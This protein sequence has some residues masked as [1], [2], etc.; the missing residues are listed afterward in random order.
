MCARRIR[1]GMVA[2]TVPSAS[3]VRAR[4][5]PRAQSLPR[6]RSPEPGDGGAV[7]RIARESSLDLNSPYAYVMWGD[8]FASTSVVAEAHGE[9]VGFVTGF[10]LP[11]QPHTL[12][13]WQV[14]V[15]SERKREG[16]A[17]KMLD[18]LVAE[19]HDVEV[20]E[21]TVTPSNAASARLFRSFAE[22]HGAEVDESPAYAAELFPGDEHE[23]EIRFRI[24]PIARP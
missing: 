21:A 18:H 10:R 23:A 2:G 8:H 5:D 16:L 3:S 19:L 7:W 17:S 1:L 22:R 24:G 20:L 6:F 9:V 13:V 11:E 15:H 4:T 14:A 12:F